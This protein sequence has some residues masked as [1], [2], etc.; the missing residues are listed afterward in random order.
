MSEISLQKARYPHKD[1]DNKMEHES[2]RGILKFKKD[3]FVEVAWLGVEDNMD[4]FT[5]NSF[6]FFFL[7]IGQCQG[8][9]VSARN[10]FA[11][12]IGLN[13]LMSLD[14]KHTT[15]LRKGHKPTAFVCLV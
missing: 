1:D 14:F 4:E 15:Y 10:W 5:L 11:T 12:K 3:I 7:I 13:A 8:I 6:N 9:R 2:R